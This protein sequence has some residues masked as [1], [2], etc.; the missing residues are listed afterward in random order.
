[1]V[2]IKK[3]RSEIDKSFVIIFLPPSPLKIK[4]AIGRREANHYKKLQNNKRKLK[5][6]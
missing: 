5:P 3:E 4:H 1:M 2:Q 6:A